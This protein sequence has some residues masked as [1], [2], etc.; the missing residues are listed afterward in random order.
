MLNAIKKENLSDQ[1][2]LYP[3]K[4]NDITVDAT[5]SYLILFILIFQD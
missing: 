5:G 3:I 1:I 4:L 2:N